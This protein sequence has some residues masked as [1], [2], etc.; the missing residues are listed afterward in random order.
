MKAKYIAQ[1][2]QNLTNV[3]N[4]TKQTKRKAFMVT[5]EFRTLDNKYLIEVYGNGWAYEVTN[6]EDDEQNLWFQDSDAEQL[7]RD[8]NNF[9]DTAHLDTMFE[10][11][12]N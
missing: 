8:T 11:L 12:F 9:E 7:Q 1:S 4:V 6:L 10:C 3:R 5:N 2:I